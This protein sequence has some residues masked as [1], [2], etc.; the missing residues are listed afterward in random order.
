LHWPRDTLYLEKLTPTSPTC[1]GRLVG[2]VRVLTKTTEF[3]FLFVCCCCCCGVF[4]PCK[5]CNTE[6]RSRNY[7]TVDEAVFSP[8]RTELCRAVPRDSCMDD[9]RVGDHVSSDDAPFNSDA[10]IEVPLEGALS[11]CLIKGL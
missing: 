1:S 6:R 10:T 3:V 5:N 2:I 8:C 9:A 4:T 7:A 11:T